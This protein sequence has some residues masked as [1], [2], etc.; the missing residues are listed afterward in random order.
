MGAGTISPTAAC[1]CP[2]PHCPLFLCKVGLWACRPP[3]KLQLCVLSIDTVF[4]SLVSEMVMLCC[5][6]IQKC[7]FYLYFF[8]IGIS[9]YC[10]DI[11]MYG[12]KRCL[13][14]LMYVVVFILYNV[15]Y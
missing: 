2:P 11:I 1:R 6:E 7:N 15:E 8:N 5:L 14:F 3:N 12:G 9:T 13:R 10:S 4:I